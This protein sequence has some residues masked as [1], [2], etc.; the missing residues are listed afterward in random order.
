MGASMTRTE[1]KS[2]RHNKIYESRV[3]GVAQGAFR[4]RKYQGGAYCCR[5]L[6]H[7][8]NGFSTIDVEARELRGVTDEGVTTSCC[9][10]N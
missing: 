3:L 9:V 10:D 2:R 4:R 7:L 6:R 1:G 5:S 8:P